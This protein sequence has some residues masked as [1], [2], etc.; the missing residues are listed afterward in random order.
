MIIRPYRQRWNLEMKTKNK[1]IAV[2]PG[3]FDPV[4]NGHLDIIKRGL[5]MFDTLIVAVAHNPGKAPT[6]TVAERMELIREATRNLRNI[7][8]DQFQNLLTD[9]MRSV[10]GG[11]IIRGLRAVTD[12]EFELQMGLM[13]RAL[14]PSVETIFVIPSEEYSFLS[15]RLIKEIV[16]LK[17]SVKGLVPRGVEPLLKKK[18]FSA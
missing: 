7:R 15:S 4:T 8:V 12:Y 3:T 5:K 14:D 9:Y 6:F 1:R 17:G 13:N 18:N 10:G 2:Y 11:V 16:Q